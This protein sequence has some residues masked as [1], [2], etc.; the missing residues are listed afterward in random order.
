MTKHWSYRRLQ[1][2]F[3]PVE[4]DVLKQAVPFLQ[5][6]EEHM[7]PAV[8]DE[9]HLSIGTVQLDG[10]ALEGW[11]RNVQS[12]YWGRAVQVSREDEDRT[13]GRW[14][15][16]QDTLEELRQAIVKAKDRAAA[17]RWGNLVALQKRVVRTLA[18]YNYHLEVLHRV[19]SNRDATN[20][21]PGVSSAHLAFGSKTNR[22][23][24][25][26]AMLLIDS[27]HN[28]STKP[29][30]VEKAEEMEWPGDI[31]AAS[32]AAIWRGVKRLGRSALGLEDHE[33]TPKKYTRFKGFRRLVQ[34][35]RSGTLISGS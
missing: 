20:K 11:K 8:F 23:H 4:D 34:D 33:P 13:I 25:C 24:L 35:L 30:F 19:E 18:R 6:K 16:G 7:P 9:L 21:L 2:L 26:R 5:E 14:K 12:S 27:Y 22:E 32:G 28:I 29:K 31:G 15:T 3:L 1:G 10:E 17:E